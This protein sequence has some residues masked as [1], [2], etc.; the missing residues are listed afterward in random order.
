[1]AIPFKIC[2]L[3]REE[4]VRLAGAAGASYLGFIVVAG[5]PRCVPLGR[6]GALF[7][8]AARFRAARVLVAGALPLAE[9]QGL[10]DEYRPEI[11]QLHRNEPAEYAAALRGVRVWR[12]WHLTDAA[13]VEEA[14]RYPC[15]AV[16]AD[17][18]GG[19]T[20]RVCDWGLARRLAAWRPVV[21]AGGIT[22]ANAAAA[23]A[24][25]GAFAVDCGSG[26]EAAPGVKDPEKI[27]ALSKACK[28]ENTK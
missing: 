18:G 1:M 11:V 28:E 7:A 3:T 8:E 16:V 19:G 5:T 20:G 4:D 2:G 9:L 14:A 26:T 21:V 12:A 22:A 27:L 10:V 23:F 6:L 15:E 13:V 24:A 17:T 25:S